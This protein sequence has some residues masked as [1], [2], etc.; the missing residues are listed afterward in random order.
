M[1]SRPFSPNSQRKIKNSDTVG[2]ISDAKVMNSDTVTTISKS[3]QAISGV[4]PQSNLT[5][6][7]GGGGGM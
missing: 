2:K 5:E 6:G 1:L 4:Q 3:D 7:G